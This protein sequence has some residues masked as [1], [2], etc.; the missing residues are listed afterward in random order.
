MIYQP[1][2]LPTALTT[3]S[4]LAPPVYEEHRLDQLY[5]QIDLSGFMTPAGGASGM[6]TPF[7][8]QTPAGSTENVNFIDAVAST[9]SSA[10]V[11]QTR[12][13]GLEHPASGRRARDRPHHLSSSVDETVEDNQGSSRDLESPQ[14]Y[15][16]ALSTGGNISISRGS[17]NRPGNSNP[18]SRRTSEGESVPTENQAPE[19]IEFSSE[20]LAKVPS[21]STALR[22]RV[23][24]PVNDGL[25]NYQA[26]IQTPISQSSPT[27]VPSPADNRGSPENRTS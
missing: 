13:H 10:N 8:S 18:M 20:D 2:M 17:P 16:G 15:Q 5:S 23:T 19:H 1:D 14:S 9:S 7:V 25:P 21:Y 11:S 3:V 12:L 6:G 26:A 22:S 4:G 27:Q 24:A